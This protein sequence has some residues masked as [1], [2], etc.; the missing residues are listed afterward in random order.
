[1]EIYEKKG[2]LM[3]NFRLFHLKDKSSKSFN[4]HYHDFYKIL[5]MITGKVNYT[6]EGKTYA[7]QPYDIVLV[8]KGEIHRPEI[9]SGEYERIIIYVSSD[10]IDSFKKDDEGLD[11]CFNRAHD[12]NSSVLRLPG[13]KNSA[14]GKALFELEDSTKSEGY[15]SKLYRDSKF[16][17][18]MVLLNRVSLLENIN[19]LPTDENGKIPEILEYINGNL[20][21]DMSVEYIANKFFISRYHLMHTFKEETGCTIGSYISQKRL[22]LYNTLRRQGKSTT[23]AALEAGFKSYPAFLHTFKKS[24]GETPRSHSKK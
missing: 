15:A 5:I 10:F 13:F 21:E 2:Y 19:Y 18:F 24:F 1:M 14:L 4:F 6:I 7:L 8:N 12:H 3:E 22:M 20:T 11:L 9:S 17:E 16:L 23:D